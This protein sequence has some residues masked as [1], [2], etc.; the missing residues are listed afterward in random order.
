MVLNH[1]ITKWLSWIKLGHSWYMPAAL[2]PTMIADTFN[3]MVGAV[4]YQINTNS[5][6]TTMIA[7]Q[8]LWYNAKHSTHWTSHK[9][10]KYIMFKRDHGR[11]ATRR[12]S[13]LGF[14]FLREITIRKCPRTARLFILWRFRM[15]MNKHCLIR[16][17]KLCW[18][19]EFHL[20]VIQTSFTQTV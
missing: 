1:Q 4:R 2:F 13:Y 8:W 19:S 9:A 18:P 11:A 14:G 5:S 6:S 10:L 3:M 17:V 12:V 16:L 15:G 20:L 7:K